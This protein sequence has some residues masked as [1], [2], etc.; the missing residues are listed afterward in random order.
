MDKIYE[1]IIKAY[2][3]KQ[4]KK[5]RLQ[6]GLTQEQMAERLDISPRSY[7]KIEHGQSICKVQTL[8][9]FLSLYKSPEKL[10]KDILRLI[11]ETVDNAQ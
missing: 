1:E 3:A 6:K 10:M 2:L 7:S 5:T 11:E 4:I 8:F 9:H